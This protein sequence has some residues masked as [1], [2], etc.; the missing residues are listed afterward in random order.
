MKHAYLIMAHDCPRQLIMLLKLLDCEEN[1]IYLHIDKKNT[2]IDIEAMYE[3]IKKAQLHI[4]KKYKVY[5]ADLSQTR[6]QLYLLQVASKSYHDYYH[7]ISGHDLPL[8]NNTQIN[9]FFSSHNNV[10][11]VHFETQTYANKINVNY[12]RLFRYIA[13][14]IKNTKVKRFFESVDTFFINFQK[15]KKIRRKLYCGANWF[16]ITHCF[17]EDL[18][19][20]KYKVLKRLLFMQSSDE[21]LLQVFIKEVTKNK[22]TLFSYRDNDYISIMRKIDWERGS[23][24]VWRLRDF[25]ELINS[26]MLFAR[27]FDERIDFEI[28]NKIY[29]HI[30][31]SL[32]N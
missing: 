19:K 18:L 21:S 23:P 31:F 14:R 26:D 5:W 16:S 9:D 17:A 22:Y 1:D 20:N 8:K 12:Y 29:E 3:V 25:N 4:Y 7:L 10:E 2:D 32:N 13:I 6:C 27:K 15:S 30:L 11:F 28:I 24:Y